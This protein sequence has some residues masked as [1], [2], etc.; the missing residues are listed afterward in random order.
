MDVPPGRWYIIWRNNCAGA[1]GAAG[2]LWFFFFAVAW[3]PAAVC[4]G[5]GVGCGSA[6]ARSVGV[7]AFQAAQQA[8]Q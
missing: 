1:V 7:D 6:V 4:V 3:R 5:V 8:A 2:C